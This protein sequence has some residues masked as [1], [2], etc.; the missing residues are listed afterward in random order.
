MCVGYGVFFALPF[1]SICLVYAKRAR[2]RACVCHFWLMQKLLHTRSRRKKRGQ[3]Q[4][5]WY[6][7]RF[8]HFMITKFK[9][10]SSLC[11]WDVTFFSSST[12]FNAKWNELWWRFNKN[13]SKFLCCFRQLFVAFFSVLLGSL[14]A[15]NSDHVILPMKPKEFNFDNCGFS[16]YVCCLKRTEINLLDIR[17][18]MCEYII[19]F[20]FSKK[21]PSFQNK[22]RRASSM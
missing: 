16:Y 8:S 11:V 15:L 3:P 9:L 21:I 1:D 14:T 13:T 18:K 17:I 7:D 22:N 10:L 6:Y 12:S 4:M 2:V 5:K 20:I 19:S